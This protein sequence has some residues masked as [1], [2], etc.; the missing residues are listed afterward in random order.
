MSMPGGRRR[1]R[2]RDR[3]S[4]EP[5]AEETA[6]NDHQ[7]REDDELNAAEIAQVFGGHIDQEGAEDWADQGAHSS[8]HC[9]A[10]D[11]SGLPQ[12]TEL[13]ADELGEVPIE[14][15][16]KSADGRANG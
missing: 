2:W 11:D 13:G 9:H 1:V 14:G 12:E 15:T 7:E 8:D 3:Q 4:P 6:E 5:L 10:D 16:G